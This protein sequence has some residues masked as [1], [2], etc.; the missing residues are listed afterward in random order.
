MN[1]VL[2]FETEYICFYSGKVKR[3]LYTADSCTAIIMKSCK[4]LLWLYSRTYNLLISGWGSVNIGE[5]TA[6]DIISE[7]DWD[8]MGDSE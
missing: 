7:V 6:D 5:Q 2:L 3:Q 4:F 8:N 1:V